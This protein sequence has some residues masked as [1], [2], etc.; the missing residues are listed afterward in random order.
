LL[1][2]GHC[3]LR[4]ASANAV[5]AGYYRAMCSGSSSDV[6]RRFRFAVAI[7]LLI[8]AGCAQVRYTP[9]A[10]EGGT[11]ESELPAGPR[12]TP[13]DGQDAATIAQLRAAPAKEPELSTGSS[14][15]ADERL[16]NARG[17]A[18]VGNGYFPK[19][20]ADARAWAMH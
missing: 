12:Y 17:Y 20:G 18:R 1:N 4:I 9:P 16:F 2:G 19:V 15:G 10:A 14:I 8:A 5:A 3:T 13:V 7:A 6:I 11:A